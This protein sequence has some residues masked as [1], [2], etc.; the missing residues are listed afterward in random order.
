MFKAK[1]ITMYYG[2]YNLQVS[3]AFQKFVLHHFAF[4]KDLHWYLFLLNERNPK[5]I[6]VFTEKGKKCKQC[7]ATA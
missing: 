3:L 7:L 6:F 2:I 1:T 5:R 4:M